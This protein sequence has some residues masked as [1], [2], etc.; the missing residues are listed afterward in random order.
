MILSIAVS[1]LFVRRLCWDFGRRR[2]L[3]M[4]SGRF[5]ITSL[6]LMDKAITGSS[7]YPR[8][9]SQALR[10]ALQLMMNICHQLLGR[11]RDKSSGAMLVAVA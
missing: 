5:V 10:Q 7:R 3:G 2:L 1:F 4:D 9:K 11:C 8:D 6:W